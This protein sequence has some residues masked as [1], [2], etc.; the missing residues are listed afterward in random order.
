MDYVTFY[1]IWTGNLLDC[2]FKLL[3]LYTLT[4][5]GLNNIIYTWTRNLDY[6][7]Y[8]LLDLDLKILGL[9]IWISVVIYFTGFELENTWTANL[10]YNY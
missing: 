8:I 1:G 4:G 2:N 6:N 10:D 3:F 9:Q 5:D 7:Y